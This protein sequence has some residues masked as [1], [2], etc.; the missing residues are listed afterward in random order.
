MGLPNRYC[1]RHPAKEKR[2]AEPFLVASGNKLSQCM[3]AV[4][5]GWWHK[6][7]PETIKVARQAKGTTNRRAGNGRLL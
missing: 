6:N 2:R 5:S 3:L 1:Q 4:R 7:L